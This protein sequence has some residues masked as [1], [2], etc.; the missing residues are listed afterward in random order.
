M[1]VNAIRAAVVEFHSI[2]CKKKAKGQVLQKYLPIIFWMT[3]LSW[4]LQFLKWLYLGIAIL[5]LMYL[6]P[7]IV[8]GLYKCI[9]SFMW[10]SHTRSP[11]VTF[12]C[13]SQYITVKWENVVE[14]L[15]SFLP[16]V[17]QARPTG[18]STMHNIKSSLK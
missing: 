8:V 7:E 4:P 12:K 16:H 13:R 3:V 14:T 1:T 17:P 18:N 11:F 9:K 5:N 6:I 15:P 10:V 2:V